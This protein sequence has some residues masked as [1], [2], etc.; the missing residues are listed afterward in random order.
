[1]QCT[2]AF[3][4]FVLALTD[5]VLYVACITEFLRWSGFPGNPG[6]PDQPS[7]H[8][9]RMTDGLIILITQSVLRQFHSRIQSDLWRHRELVLLSTSRIVLFP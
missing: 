7:P 6:D 9:V 3:R 5:D 4:S 8:V 1:M 2:S